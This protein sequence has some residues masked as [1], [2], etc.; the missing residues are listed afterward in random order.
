MDSKQKAKDY[1]NKAFD[2]I[3]K[4]FLDEEGDDAEYECQLLVEEVLDTRAGVEEIED[5][6]EYI[7]FEPDEELERKMN[8][9]EDEEDD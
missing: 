4:E 7:A 9:E 5:D 6:G 1:L 2:Y 3:V 8:E